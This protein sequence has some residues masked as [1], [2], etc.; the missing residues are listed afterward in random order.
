MLLKN[1]RSYNETGKVVFD[2]I[3]ITL[4]NLWPRI[5]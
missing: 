5:N 1:D 3:I 4:G 2:V